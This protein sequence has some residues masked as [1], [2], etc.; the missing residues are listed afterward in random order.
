MRVPL[1]CPS[2]GYKFRNNITGHPT[3]KT[4]REGGKPPIF[5]LCK[6]SAGK[7]TIFGSPSVVSEISTE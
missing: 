5:K 7:G 4:K 2:E 3:F 6:Y 1:Q